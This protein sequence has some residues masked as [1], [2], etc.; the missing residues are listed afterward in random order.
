MKTHRPCVSPNFRFESD[1]EEKEGLEIVN[2]RV[3]GAGTAAPPTWHVEGVR[4]GLG[5]V[6]CG[7][8]SGVWGLG[9]GVWGLGFR[10]SGFG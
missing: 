2:F 6:V 8:G 9:F 5:F 1:K 4:V 10:I 3:S 7:L